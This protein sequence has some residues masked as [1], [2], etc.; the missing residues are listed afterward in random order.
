[1]IEGQSCVENIGILEVGFMESWA[2]KG[3][4]EAVQGKILDIGDGNIEDIDVIDENLKN[5]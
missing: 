5:F 2:K 1:M 4:G 3:L